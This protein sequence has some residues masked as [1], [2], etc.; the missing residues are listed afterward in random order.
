[1][2]I[3]A[4]AVASVPWVTGA[5]MTWHLWAKAKDWK[6]Y[7]DD[8]YIEWEITIPVVLLWLAVWPIPLVAFV[9]YVAHKHSPR[10]VA[11]FF[12]P[13]VRTDRLKKEKSEE[14]QKQL[15]A[16]KVAFKETS[17]PLVRDG[18]REAAKTLCSDWRKEDKYA[19][20]FYSSEWL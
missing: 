6:P 10:V 11:E 5:A 3:V 19:Q 15:D 7:Y 2:M 12:A 16:L 9:P 1:M 8:G 13:G 4:I 17:E 18:L 14:Y 20:G